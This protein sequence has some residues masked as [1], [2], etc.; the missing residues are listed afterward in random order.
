MRQKGFSPIIIVLLLGL[1]ILGG[2]F[3]LKRA[4]LSIPGLTTQPES[5]QPAEMSEEVSDAGDSDTLNQELEETQ[6]D[7]FDSDFN[8]LDSS[9]SQM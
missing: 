4:G 5:T 2:F 7:S 9:A 3:F 1:L 8:E 6:L